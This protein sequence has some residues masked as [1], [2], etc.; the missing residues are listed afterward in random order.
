MQKNRL[1][2]FSDGVVAILITIMVLELKAPHETSLEALIKL[3]PVFLSYILSFLYV[4]IYWN[5][6]H[7]LL[8]SV[9]KVSGKTLWANLHWLFW[10]SLIPF[11]SAWMGENNFAELTVGLYGFVLLL[12]GFAYYILV[13]NLVSHHG[14]D[15]VVSRAVGKSNKEKI[16]VGLYLFALLISQWQAWVSLFI[17][18]IVALI[19]IYPDSRIE[20]VLQSEKNE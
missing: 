4:G 15:S 9:N 16:S 8:H 11:A 3:L 6:H 13:R 1:E 10:L 14:E 2:A 17:Y 7:H 19:W 18:F 12:T 20:K 5:N